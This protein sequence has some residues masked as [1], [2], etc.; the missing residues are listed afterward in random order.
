MCGQLPLRPVRMRLPQASQRHPIRVELFFQGCHSKHT[1]P[2][3]PKHTPA[4][5]GLRYGE[6]G[7]V[8][9]NENRTPWSTPFPRGRAAHA[10]GKPTIAGGGDG[11]TRCLLV[12]ELAQPDG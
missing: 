12:G 5:T 7:R 11:G 4:E 6:R 3:C 9:K 1:R 8:T 10:A 2:L